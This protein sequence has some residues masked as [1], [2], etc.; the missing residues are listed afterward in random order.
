M[1]HR[2]PGTWYSINRCWVNTWILWKLLIADLTYRIVPRGWGKARPGYAG[3][4]HFK[5]L[6]KS[7]RIKT[8]T[9]Y[10]CTRYYSG[11]QIQA[12][13][14]LQCSVH[15][16]G[17]TYTI[18]QCAT[19]QN[20]T[21]LSSLLCHAKF[22]C[23]GQ[24]IVLFGLMACPPSSQRVKWKGRWTESKDHGFD[25]TVTSCCVLLGK[26]LAGFETTCSYLSH[27]EAI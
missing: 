20:S 21:L 13:W 17:S 10:G 23:L 5:M 25:S 8:K 6:I 15:K 14:R 27:K 22:S 1:P 24:P 26:S 4:S 16:G 2:T 18:S 3:P 11:N 9:I 19:K 7:K 12:P